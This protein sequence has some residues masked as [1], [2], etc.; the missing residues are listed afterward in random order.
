MHFC[1]H[2]GHLS[3]KVLRNWDSCKWLKKVCVAKLHSSES[4][5]HTYHKTLA[6][7]DKCVEDFSWFCV[8]CETGF[9]R[10]VFSRHFAKQVGFCMKHQRNFMKYCRDIDCKK[11]NFAKCEKCVEVTSSSL[12]I[13]INFCKMTAKYGRNAISVEPA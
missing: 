9:S 7:C 12:R 6:K 4:R 11:E 5:L 8:F 3:S 1:W 2:S 10:F 13:R